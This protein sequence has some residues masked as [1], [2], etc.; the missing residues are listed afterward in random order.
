[1]IVN[2][3]VMTG[4][5]SREVDRCTRVRCPRPRCSGRIVYNGNYFCE[6]WQPSF[7]RNPSRGDCDWAL[8]H[9]ASDPLN[10]WLCWILVGHVEGTEKMIR[11]EWQYSGDDPEPPRDDLS[12]LTDPE[13]FAHYIALI[14][15][16]KTA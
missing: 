13:R 6:F 1:M 5:T 16:R 4:E 2:F 15:E 12:R 7:L 3:T 9:P 11:G 14:E 10:R 8:P